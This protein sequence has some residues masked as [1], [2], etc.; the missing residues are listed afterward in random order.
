MQ[1]F[2]NFFE[3]LSFVIP[4]AAL[5]MGTR[6]LWR[7]WNKRSPIYKF[8]A[9]LGGLITIAG[10][11]FLGMTLA[12][13]ILDSQLETCRTTENYYSCGENVFWLGYPVIV[14]LISF[15]FLLFGPVLYKIA[16]TLFAQITKPS[17]SGK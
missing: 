1:F 2:V 4:A 14:L 11:G 3:W 6:Y 10:V 8:G 17:V 16:H 5:S 9:W 13:K 12:I 15:G 7:G